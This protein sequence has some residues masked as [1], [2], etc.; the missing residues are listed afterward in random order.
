VRAGPA[1]WCAAGPWSACCRCWS[2]RCRLFV[3][4]FG[5]GGAGAGYVDDGFAGGERT[6][7]SQW[8]PGTVARS[9][10]RRVLPLAFA[11]RA[12]TVPRERHRPGVP[13]SR[14]RSAQASNAAVE[15]GLS[16][17][18]SVSSTAA[19][20]HVRSALA[21]VANCTRCASFSPAT[22]CSPHRPVSFINWLR[23]RRSARAS[24]RSDAHVRPLRCA[25]GSFVP[26]PRP[27]RFVHCLLSG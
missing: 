7:W 16:R 19:G 22:A 26:G 2:A 21:T 9:L 6:S 10:R 8:N 17:R 14:P 15:P 20:D 5:D 18:S 13:A 23:C 12:R 27:L 24:D 3:E 25:E 11:A 1:A 4:D